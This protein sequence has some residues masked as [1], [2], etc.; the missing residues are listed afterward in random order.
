MK[1]RFRGHLFITVL[2]KCCALIFQS[3]KTGF[4]DYLHNSIYCVH[5]LIISDNV[6]LHLDSTT[7][8]HLA[9]KNND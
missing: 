8:L 1:E 7:P 2:L 4:H 6:S 3:I 5:V 9:D